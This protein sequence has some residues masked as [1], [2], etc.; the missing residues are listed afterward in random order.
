MDEFEY[1]YETLKQLAKEL[2]RPI[3][4]LLGLSR[5]NDPFYVGTEADKRDGTWFREL[6]EQ[7]GFT[8]G[9]HIRR[10]HY[11]MVSQ[12]PPV[13]LPNGK[14]YENTEECWKF[15]NDASKAARYLKYVDPGAFVDRRNE[16]PITL[17][18]SPVTPMVDVSIGEV[19][20]PADLQLSF[21]AIPEYS[22]DMFNSPQRYHLEIWCEKSTMNDIFIPLIRRYR[23][24]LMFGKGELSITMALEAVQRFKRVAKPV[25]IFYVSDFDPAGMCMPVSMARK[26]EYFLHKMKLDLDIKLFPV[27]LTAEQ[28]KYY[29]RLLPTPI[30]KEERRK[31]KFEA[32]F[33]SGDG[34]NVAVELDALEALYPGELRRLLDTELSRYYDDDLYQRIS[35]AEDETNELLEEIRD[36]VYERHKDEIAEIEQEEEEL[37]AIFDEQIKERMARHSQRKYELALTIQ[38]ELEEAQPDLSEDDVPEAEEAEER[39]GAL[40]DSSRSYLEQN[41]VY[42]AHKGNGEEDM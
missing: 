24:V 37:Q 40:F 10:M 16:E 22:L 26:V 8:T 19:E 9:V 34:E 41:E 35:E 33:G 28:V 36:E 1:N 15:L 23:A 38:T 17:Y 21:P 27:V 39:N 30:K 7:F 5:T 2:K 12:N 3:T 31:A 11:A 25:R 29:D 20:E 6:W 4:S 32:R 14:T 42:Q 18:Q 13:K